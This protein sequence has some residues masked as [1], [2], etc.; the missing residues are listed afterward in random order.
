MR[1]LPL[2]A[3]ALVF[4]LVKQLGGTYHPEKKL[5]GT[6]QELTGLLKGSRRTYNWYQRRERWIMKNGGAFHYGRH[7]DPV[8]LLAVQLVLAALGMAALAGA[9]WELAA[10]GAAML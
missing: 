7:V 1:L 8:R 10:F 9:S 6:Y 5:F 2:C 3:G 4:A